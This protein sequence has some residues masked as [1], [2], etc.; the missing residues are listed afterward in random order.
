MFDSGSESDASSGGEGHSGGHHGGGH[1]KKSKGASMVTGF[2]QKKAMAAA[3]GKQEGT[4]TVPTQ[5]TGQPLPAGQAPIQ[6]QNYGPGQVPHQNGLPHQEAPGHGPV[7]GAA[8]APAVEPAKEEKPGMLDR[9]NHLPFHS[10]LIN[11]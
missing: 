5:S 10:L 2:I 3:K 1:H 9:R 11:T 7:P 6:Q 8:P 4:A